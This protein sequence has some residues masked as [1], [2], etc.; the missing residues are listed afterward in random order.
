MMEPAP[1]SFVKGCGL[2]LAWADQPAWRILDTD[3]LEGRQFLAAWAAWQDDPRRPRMLHYVAILPLGPD[4]AKQAISSQST[5][6]AASSRTDTATRLANQCLALTP[7]FNRLEFE[8]G[9]VLLTLCVGDLKAMLREQNF[10]ADSVFLRAEDLA[11][12]APDW[13][14]WTAKSL[15]RC[16]RRGTTIAAAGLTLQ[17]LAGL[18]QT[19]FLKQESDAGLPTTVRSTLWLAVFSPPW[20][21]RRSRGASG[22]PAATPGSC[23]VVGAGLAGA[24][25]AASMARRGWRVTVFDALDEP[26][27]GASGLPVGL[28]APQVSKDRN[29]RTRLSWHGVRLTLQQAELLLARGQHWAQTGVLQHLPDAPAL[30][31]AMAGWIKPQQ[32]VKSWL[33]QPGIRS[34]AGVHVAR[35]DRVKDGQLGQWQLTDSEGNPVACAD[36]VVIAAALGSRPLLAQRGIQAPELHG[37]AGQISWGLRQ[38]A[39]TQTLEQVLPPCPVNGNGSFI[40]SVPGDDGVAWY[41]GATFETGDAISVDAGHRANFGRLSDLLPDVA[42]VLAR[43]FESADVKAWR[44]VRCA[45]KDRMP[46]VGP[47]PGQQNQGL[48]ISTG[49]G[50]R[51]LTWSVLAAEL[52]AAR[53]GGEPW[54]VESSLARFIDVRRQNRPSALAE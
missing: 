2:P 25:V 7:G 37:I 32:L 52:L 40:P 51:G 18:A 8:R 17:R 26:A 35:M 30:W 16:C 27:A 24:S 39:D 21:L 3:W 19:G 54:P 46:L 53:L 42:A 11:G 22:H 47:L 9:R 45:T 15:A 4:P 10:L 44:G 1:Q 31:H 14:L 50:S 28:L 23:I 20:E 43:Q 12:T 41:S 33:A 13:D 36:V 34:C 6:L 48:W 5:V 49:F 29:A 38:R